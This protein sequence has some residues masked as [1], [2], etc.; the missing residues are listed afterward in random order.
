[1]CDKDHREYYEGFEEGKKFNP[2]YVKILK[3]LNE[4]QK[5]LIKI[6]DKLLWKG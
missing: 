3:K 4:I 6:I 1:M 2:E 5:D